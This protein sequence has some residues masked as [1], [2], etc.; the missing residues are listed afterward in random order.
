LDGRDEDIWRDPELGST[1][2]T[3]HSG[4]TFKVEDYEQKASIRKALDK[5]MAEPF[6]TPPLLFEN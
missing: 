2:T 1:P 5:K 6:L 3:I 4:L